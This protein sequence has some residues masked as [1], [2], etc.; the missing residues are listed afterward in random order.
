MKQSHSIALKTV[1]LISDQE[2][3]VHC[4]NE[5]NYKLFYKIISKTTLKARKSHFF[6]QFSKVKTIKSLIHHSQKPT[7]SY[8]NGRISGQIRRKKSHQSHIFRHLLTIQ[9]F[10]KSLNLSKMKAL[11]KERRCKMRQVFQKIK[12]QSKL[13]YIT[14]LER[15]V[16]M[17]FLNKLTIIMLLLTKIHNF[18][19]NL[20]LRTRSNS[21]RIILKVFIMNQINRSYRMMVNK[22]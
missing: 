10:R 2:K 14:M 1:Y 17:F 11:L 15:L 7:N 4:E 9:R 13:C 16:R 6:L 20:G 18:F 5:S 21:A 19:L 22:Q 12:L 3:L 8:H